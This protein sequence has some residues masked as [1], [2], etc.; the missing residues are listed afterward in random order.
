MK[1]KILIVDDEPDMAEL[2][3]GSLVDAGHEASTALSGESAL[4]KVR[5]SKPDLIILDVMLPEMN[6]LEVCKILRRDMGFAHLPIIMV[7]ARASATD[8]V[9]GLEFG[10]DDY[11]TK[12]FSMRELI[13]RVKKMLDVLY[14]LPEDHGDVIR[15]NALVIDPLE[16][17]VT[18]A[19]KGLSLTP[20]E[21]K[22]LLILVRRRGIVQS[23]E[24]LLTEVWDFRDSHSIETRTVDTLMRRLREKLGS[25]ASYLETV[26]GVGYRFAEQSIKQR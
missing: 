25:V 20:M 23:R 8:R 22:T 12:P 10:A 9:I 7:S 11:I 3:Q 6:G 4:Q 18:L 17:S 16:Y 19:G 24:Q 26:R 1:R 21:F 13:I 2:I 5:D 14:R 15:Y